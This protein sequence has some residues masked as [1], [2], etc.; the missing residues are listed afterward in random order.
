MRRDYKP[1]MI[2]TIS[3]QWCPACG[4]QV[5]TYLELCDW[6]DWETPDECDIATKR[7]NDIMDKMN[8]PELKN[9]L[10]FG[11]GCGSVCP[12]CREQFYS[13]SEVCPV[14]I[15]VAEDLY[16]V[17]MSWAL[18]HHDIVEPGQTMKQWGSQLGPFA[19]EVVLY[20][21]ELALK[22]AVDAKT[23]E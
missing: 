21:L 9:R 3:L 2:P 16:N 15:A 8:R 23:I 11:H 4:R 22:E 7:W 12:S 18:T 14:N 19:K 1:R 6:C 10:G 5:A 13:H 17:I 20:K